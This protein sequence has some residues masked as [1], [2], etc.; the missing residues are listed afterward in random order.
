M[1]SALGDPPEVASGE[2]LF[3]HIPWTATSYCDLGLGATTD[4]YL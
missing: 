3:T 1:T 4:V 2:G